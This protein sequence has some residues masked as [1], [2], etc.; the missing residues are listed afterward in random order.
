MK[1]RGIVRGRKG[2]SFAS[3]VPEQGVWVLPLVLEPWRDAA[4]TLRSGAATAWQHATTSELDERHRSGPKEGAVVELSVDRRAEIVGLERPAIATDFVL[5]EWTEIVDLDLVAFARR[6]RERLTRVED[7]V[8]GTFV[9]DETLVGC[10]VARR[11]LGTEGEYDVVVTP[12][13]GESI[14]DDLANIRGDVAWLEAN[15][16]R[17]RHDVADLLWETWSEH[18]RD[19]DEANV[20]RVT[21]E[22]AFHITGA[23][24]DLSEPG[25]SW[26][27][28]DDG[29]LF[30]GHSVH[31]RVVAR[32]VV[33]AELAG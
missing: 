17:I 13:G 24:F 32:Q 16:E 26:I 9:R 7:A 19:A 2:G 14:A 22:T 33:D 3:F 10:Y 4:G 27:D 28:L 11:R 1:I 5:I 29:D 8:L 23:S 30:G 12:R 25:V 21:F 15:A 20:D 31:A 6:E 18:W